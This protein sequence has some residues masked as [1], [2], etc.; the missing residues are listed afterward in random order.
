VPTCTLASKYM[1]T[2]TWSV[3]ESAPT[4][5]PQVQVIVPISFQVRLKK[6]SEVKKATYK[7]Q[8]QSEQT[9]TPPCL[10]TVNEPSAEPGNLCV[11]SG[12]PLGGLEAQQ[13]NMAFFQFVEP[14]GVPFTTSAKVG[15]LGE[16]VEFRST[17]NEPAF[18]EEAP[19]A[20]ESGYGVITHSAYMST[21]GS[22]A[23]QEK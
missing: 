6:G 11:Y 21:L 17:E 7:N 5:A 3:N 10:G 22:W 18:K 2:G 9:T 15:V 14:S 19:A 16:G 1:E 20:G 23:V 4:G 13:A 12:A 8:L